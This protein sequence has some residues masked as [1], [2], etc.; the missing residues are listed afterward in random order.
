MLYKD[1]DDQNFAEETESKMRMYFILT[2]CHKKINT[3]SA[4]K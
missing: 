1:H 3:W 2:S 4:Y